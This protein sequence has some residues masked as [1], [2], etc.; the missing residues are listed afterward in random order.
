MKILTH[1]FACGGS[2]I[3]LELELNS[4]AQGKREQGGGVGGR[5]VASEYKNLTNP[6][7]EYPDGILS[8]GILC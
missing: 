6:E 1:I 4:R 7:K 5:G 2:L 8:A 3:F